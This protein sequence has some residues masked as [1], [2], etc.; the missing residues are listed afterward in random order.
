MDLVIKKFNQNLNAKTTSSLG[1]ETGVIL[2]LEAEIE[3][4][5]QFLSYQKYY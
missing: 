2:V 4:H 5:I 3:F 1:F